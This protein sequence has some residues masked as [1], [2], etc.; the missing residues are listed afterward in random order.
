MEDKDKFDRHGYWRSLNELAGQPEFKENLGREFPETVLEGLAGL[1][2]RSFLGLMGA[3]LALAGLAGCRKPVEKIIPY[4]TPPEEI[5]PGI[6]NYYATT[7]PMGTD[8][9][10]VIVECHEGRPTKIEGNPRHP[11]TRGAANAWILASILGLYDPDRSP[12]IIHKGLENN[13]NDFVAF[14]RE[15][16]KKYSTTGGEGLAILTEPFSSP[17]LFNALQMFRRRFP[18]A[19]VKSWSPVNYKNS[20]STLENAAPGKLKT[21]YSLDKAKVILSLDSDFL[22]A[23][24]DN[25][26]AAADF[27]KGRK[28]DSPLDSMNRLYVVESNYSLTGAMAD[29]RLRL[30][31]D[32]LSGFI[33]ALAGELIRRGVNINLEPASETPSAFS[34]DETWI[35]ALA[36]D[37]SAHKGEGLIRVGG[38]H[39]PEL[40]LAVYHLNRALGNIGKTVTYYEARDTFDDNLAPENLLAKGTGDA[41]ST[42]IL[43]GVNPVYASTGDNEIS[44]ALA[45]IENTIHFGECFDETAE[46]C[47]WH[48]P[49]AHYLESWGD[50][51]AADGIAGV[52]QP[53]IAPLYDGRSTVELWN[54]LATA[55]D[56]TGYEIVRR[57]WAGILPAADFENKWRQILHDGLLD[58]SASKPIEI[59]FAD[60]SKIVI[61]DSRATTSGKLNLVVVP[62]TSVFD[63]RFA[64]SSWLQELPDP[65]TKL[66]WDNAALVS[67]A[68]AKNL[69]LQN[70]DMV[71]I[72]DSD[73]AVPIWIQPGISENTVVMN[74]GYGR[75]R[76]GRI[77]TG[78]GF[79]AYKL[80]HKKEISL[81]KT[82]GRHHFANTQE[83]GA[84]EGRAIFREA[85]LEKYRRDPKFAEKMVE[86]P[87]LK[88]IFKEHSYDQGYQW[89]MTID[90]NSCIGCGACTIACQS[91]NNIPVVGKEQ[92]INGREM[93]W[94]RNDR[95]FVGESDDPRVV[96][97]PMACQ[98]CENAPCESVCPVSATTHD[99][100]GL[101][102]MTYNR[103]IGTRYCSNNCPYKVRRFNFFN[104][105]KDMPETVKMA[106]N[107]D[108]TVRFRGVMEKCTFCVQRINRGKQA[109]KK[110]NRTVRDGE[111]QTACQQ[112][113]PTKAISFG[114]ILDPDS[115][116]AQIKKSDRNY[117]L[118]A[119]LNV[120]P[121]NTY[122]A[123]IRN[124]QP[125]LMQ[126]DSDMEKE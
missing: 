105:T 112:A 95:Y 40:G 31:P 77:G 123:R 9:Y 76:A 17:S 22:A 12:K 116:V 89:G 7:M 94:I 83:H 93:H 79:N 13:W 115:N 10:G 28:V 16:D 71:R 53:M 19:L 67:I 87:P 46:H 30:S 103:C 41:I 34:F 36:E 119:E 25:L 2:R 68:T 106:Q 50:V 61:N 102:V 60:E 59:N 37:L 43:L 69:N 114:N 99:K 49:A 38:T 32:H 51:W 90:L 8:A 54:L 82:G 73:T 29:H 23:E 111:I 55:N 20:L 56:E 124:P 42:L 39:S 72:D 117:A 15:L 108:V 98:H 84:M 91:E 63:G 47:T 64:N 11:A 96:I 126:F 14:W 74:L 109:A 18:R 6:A 24:P 104:Y 101:N 97:M 122:L 26:A 44:S 85:N 92:V 125:D 110:E 3:S 65:I 81:E 52:I 58:N 33:R 78:V 75:T 86:H 5:I 1:S 45:K 120:K 48:I 66:A 35:R 27:V 113:C 80:R 100:E 70:G 4:V 21:V 57:T 107:P 88:S 118:L 62:D 121:R